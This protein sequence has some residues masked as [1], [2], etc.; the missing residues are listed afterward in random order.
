MKLC[1]C[2]NHFILDGDDPYEA[3]RKWVTEH[4][5]EASGEKCC[6]DSSRICASPEDGE[7]G[8]HHDRREG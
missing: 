8:I 5:K 1:G 2:K 4:G 3:H 6:C 7:R